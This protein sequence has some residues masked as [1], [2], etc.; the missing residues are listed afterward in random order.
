MAFLLRM[1][2]VFSYRRSYRVGSGVLGP[3]K[4]GSTHGKIDCPI[5]GYMAQSTWVRQSRSYE[6]TLPER[7]ASGA[8]ECPKCHSDDVTR[9]RRKFVERLVLPIMRAQAYRCRDCKYRFWVGVQWR[10]VILGVISAAMVAGFALA[11]MFAHVSRERQAAEAA[12]P[13]KVRRYRA[14]RTMIPKGLPPLSSVPRPKDDPVL[15]KPGTH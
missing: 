12:A 6:P 3:S 14:P 7:G 1:H 9:S 10:Y 8:M 15:A 11:I 4:N 5:R 13:K 2:P